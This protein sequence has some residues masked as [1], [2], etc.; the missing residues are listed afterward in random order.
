MKYAD[1]KE[2]DTVNCVDGICVSL[3]MSGCPHHCKN[4]FN[5]ETW[6]PN[7]GTE[8]DVNDLS[9]K[10]NELIN[11][12]DVNRDFSILGGEPLAEYNRKNTDIIVENIRNKNPNIRICLW[13]GYTFDELKSMN[14][15]NIN[16]ILSKIDYLVDGR[17]VDEKK[18]RNLKMRG[19]SNQHILHRNGNVWKIV[20]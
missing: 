3:F 2:N 9:D 16:S 8:I 5:Q 20:E 19:S 10:L 6:N 4:C 7:Y 11:A 15:E 18:D 12:Y 14:D 17:Y 13:S 1:I